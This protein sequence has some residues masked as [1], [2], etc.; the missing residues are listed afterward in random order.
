M[1]TRR[2]VGLD[3]ADHTLEIVEL[4]QSFLSHT[5]MIVS[6]ARMPLERGVVEHGRLINKKRFTEALEV[7]WQNDSQ[8]PISTH[9]VVVGIPERQVYTYVVRFEESN[10]VLLSDLIRDSAYET[11]PIEREDLVFSSK[12]ISKKNG[13]AD[14][15]LYGTSREVLD[16]W[17]DFFEGSPYRVRAF[18]HELLALT[19]GLFGSL[20]HEPV[21][22]VDCGAERTKISISSSH[23]LDYVHSLEY[24]GDFF[25]E[26]LAKSLEVSKEEADRVKKE[27]G[28]ET[29]SHRALFEKLLKP[30]IKEI[31]VACAFFE[32]KTDKN[33][34]KI[35]LVGGSARLKGFPEYI[36]ERTNRPTQ[37]GVSFLTN[38]TR[39][40]TD[41]SL[42][43]IE[44]IGLALR[45]VQS[46]FWE[47]EH[48]SFHI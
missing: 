35:V 5:P 3:I 4:Q 25:T 33:I 46:S 38:R 9:E 34:T 43:Y 45:G 23:S 17:K 2:S 1:F 47:R 18:D 27:E 48:P 19:R 37:R 16:E 13:Y 10:G 40:D 44:A 39:I 24:A 11:I 30:I 6:R 12:I 8:C 22:V 7:L 28:M 20:E 41:D 15:L 29:L 14:V 36:Q 42:H 26:Q 21:C 32:K 31:E